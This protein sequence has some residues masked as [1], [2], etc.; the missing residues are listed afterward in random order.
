MMAKTRREEGSTH[1]KFPKRFCS[2]CGESMQ[3]ESAEPVHYDD[4]SGKLKYNTRY[5]CLRKRHWWDGHTYY[6]MITYPVQE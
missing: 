2:R 3:V 5:K 1:L 6:S 4:T